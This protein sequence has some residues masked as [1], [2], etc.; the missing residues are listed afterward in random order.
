[1]PS[2]PAANII[3]A[4]KRFRMRYGVLIA[5][6]MKIGVFLDM[7]EHLKLEEFRV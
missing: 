7:K 2:V 3:H 4:I 1:V 6:M 5:V